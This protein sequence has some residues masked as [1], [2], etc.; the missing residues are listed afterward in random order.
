MTDMVPITDLVQC[1]AGSKKLSHVALRNFIFQATG[2]QLRLKI[3]SDLI[4]F[5]IY[6]ANTRKKK[7][8]IFHFSYS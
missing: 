7:L 6:K 8:K 5:S 2:S 1:L 4:R 3:K